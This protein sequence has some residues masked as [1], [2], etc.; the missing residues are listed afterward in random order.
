MPQAGGVSPLDEQL[1]QSSGAVCEEHNAQ[2]EDLE[3]MA[4]Y[5]QQDSTCRSMVGHPSTDEA[6]QEM[7]LPA[8]APGISR[9]QT[10]VA[11]VVDERVVVGNHSGHAPF[12]RQAGDRAAKACLKSSRPPSPKKQRKNSNGEP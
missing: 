12:R 11:V 7:L 9:A 3:V 2:M 5:V 1:N 8:L 6:D 10:A 4:D